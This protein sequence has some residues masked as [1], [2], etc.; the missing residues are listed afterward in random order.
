[1]EGW[2]IHHWEQELKRQCALAKNRNETTLLKHRVR[3]E[4]TCM[5]AQTDVQRVQ[6]KCQNHDF[7]LNNQSLCESANTILETCSQI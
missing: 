6:R 2:L 4:G 3:K 5:R 7:Y 1:M